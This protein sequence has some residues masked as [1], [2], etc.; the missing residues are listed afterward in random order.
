MGRGP[1]RGEDRKSEMG[2]WAAHAAEPVAA[3]LPL[4]YSHACRPSPHN[5]ATFGVSETPTDAPDARER[6]C[7]KCGETFHG[8]ESV[9]PTDGARLLDFNPDDKADPLV[10]TL[11]DGRF[12]IYRKLG[13]GGMGNVYS[14]RQIDFERDV[15]LKVL[16]VDFIRDDNIRKRFMYEARAI[17][18]LRHPNAL[19]LFDFGQTPDGSFYMV[20]E[21]LEGESLADRLAYRFVTY[22]EI[23]NIVPPVCGVLHEAHGDRVI[24]RD[25]KPENIFLVDVNGRDE[26]AKLLDFGI[27]K[28]LQD[29]TMTQS[30]TLWGTP[31]YMS[32]EQAKGD[33]IGAPA[34]IYA[35]GVMLYEL[36]SGNLPFHSSTQMGLA[37]KHINTPARSLLTIPGLRSVPQ[38]L[39]DLI[40]QCLDKDPTARPKDA[41]EIADR[42]D[43]IKLE[44]F[45]EELLAGI[46]AEEIDAIALQDW[47]A[48]EQ[49]LG[50]DAVVPQL[51]PPPG[52]MGT[53]TGDQP[54]ALPPTLDV[55]EF[56]RPPT[57]APRWAIWV[58]VAAGV[59]LVVAGAFA[60]LSGGPT[61]ETPPG[62][63]ATEIAIA[64]EAS[65]GAAGAGAAH[66]AA[67]VVRAQG[68][69]TEAVEAM[70]F[71]E[72]LLENEKTKTKT[73]KPTGSTKEGAKGSSV[74]EVR[75]ELEKT[76]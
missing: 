28:H 66:A 20:M 29:R 69:V 27:A 31:A 5:L 45:D 9:C 33:P 17:S 40:M 65:S 44:H 24:H 47:I 50:D 1:D 3:A 72:E 7:W 6:I 70:E 25:L 38:E 46:P 68:Q 10:G 55:D 32:P 2:S 39:D 61:D 48:E 51:A 43:A 71:S 26:F 53:P 41:Q 4:A 16:K 22:A 57:R 62:T 36:I 74:K 52:A 58:G 75:S 63:R 49:P 64:P 73:E 56:E 23:F 18:K 60:F 76:F 37:M 11:F 19:R 34:D 14:A 13:E 30:G 8:T 42:L 15:A 54:L 21:L 67:V 35:V 59:V 12:R